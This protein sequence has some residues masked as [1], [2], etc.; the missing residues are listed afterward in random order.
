MSRM[1]FVII[2]ALF[3]VYA[4]SNAFASPVVVEL[5]ASQNCQSCPKAHETLGRVSSRGKDGVLV[6][7]WSVDYWDYLGDSDPMAMPE[8]KTRQAAYAERFR[9]RGPYTP[10]SVYNGEL[11]CP[12]NKPGD[13]AMNMNLLEKMQG[14]VMAW[15]DGRLAITGKTTVP[16]DIW[17]VHFIPKLETNMATITNAITAVT[18]LGDWDSQTSEIFDVSCEDECA[19]LIQDKGYGPIRSALRLN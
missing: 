5:F 4:A 7:T 11:Q 17:L 9:L 12:G 13:V 3:A 19:V 18:H 6:L 16:A 10:Q 1:R 15:A 14:P 8:S 2:L